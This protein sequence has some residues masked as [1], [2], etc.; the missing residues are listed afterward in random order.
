MLGNMDDDDPDLKPGKVLLELKA[1]VNRHQH[2]KLSLRDCQK[3]PVFEG[4]PALLMHRGD[5]VIAD[6]QPDARVYALVNEDAHSSSRL[7]A[8]SST[9]RT[10]SRET[11]G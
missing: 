11:G 6:E 9:A 7:L 1:A 10:C 3:R 4:V 2:V 5:F 8:K